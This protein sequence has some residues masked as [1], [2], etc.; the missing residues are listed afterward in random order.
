MTAFD[1]T[2]RA[3]L[4]KLH[5]KHRLSLKT[6]HARMARGVRLQLVLPHMVYRPSFYG[7]VMMLGH[8]EL[9]DETC[10][11]VFNEVDKKRMRILEHRSRIAHFEI[12]DNPLAASS[13]GL[14]AGK[15]KA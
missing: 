8:Q 4:R 1:L 14:L 13:A 11:V 15:E 7:R 2:T 5:R 3:H 10:V 9:D 12:V 6:I